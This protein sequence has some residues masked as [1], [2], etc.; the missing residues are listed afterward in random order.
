MQNSAEEA[1]RRPAG[2]HALSHS[3]LSRQSGTEQP[4]WAVGKDMVQPGVILNPRSEF[5][6][7]AHPEEARE[8]LQRVEISAICSQD[9]SW[10]EAKPHISKSRRKVL[11]PEAPKEKGLDGENRE[12]KSAERTLDQA[13]QKLQLAPEAGNDG[14]ERFFD[15]VDIASP[16]PAGRVQPAFAEAGSRLGQHSFEPNSRLK[17]GT[18]IPELLSVGNSSPAAARGGLRV[19]LPPVDASLQEEAD[20]AQPSS[21]SLSDSLSLP[22][23]AT[24]SPARSWSGNYS[25]TT[26]SRQGSPGGGHASPAVANRSEPSH[27]VFSGVGAVNRLEVNE[28]YYDA[29]EN[30]SPQSPPLQMPSPLTEKN[31]WLSRG[32]SREAKLE[33]IQ[34]ALRYCLHK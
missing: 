28:L 2:R 19:H 12:D 6:I 18:G 5:K 13:F 31:L 22:G 7:A 25:Q 9:I 34:R 16:D 15:A 32:D 14:V 26:S 17:Q 20:Q 1:A 29:L 11:N 8:K 3:A 30:P 24:H 27:G 33:T 23:T 21:E 4:S 10:E